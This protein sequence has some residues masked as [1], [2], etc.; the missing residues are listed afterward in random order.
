V[1]ARPL[2]AALAAFAALAATALAPSAQAQTSPSDFTSATRYDADHRVTGTIAP[3]PD[4]S[5][6]LHY[7]AV[8]NTY[9]DAGELTRVEKGELAAWQSEAIAP[10]D[11]E[12][13]TSFTVQQQVDTAY[14]IMGRKLVEKVLSGGTVYSLTQYSYDA[15][16]R[17][18]CT[19]LRMNAAIYGSL[20]SSAC[21]LGA[22]G[23]QGPDRITRNIYDAAD[24]LLKV[25]KAYGAPLQQDYVTYTYS[26]N[27]KQT[28]VIDANGNQAR[29][30]YDGF[31]RLAAWYF[32]STTTPGAASTTDYEAYG[33]DADGNRTSLRKRDGQ[34]I[35]YSYD[36]LNR[37]LVKDIPGGTWTDVYYDYDLAGHQLFARFGSTSGSGITNTYD[38]FGRLASSTTAMGGYSRTLSYQYD[39]DGNR[40]RITHPDGPWFDYAYDGLDR[41]VSSSWYTTATGSVQYFGIPYD[42]Q[43]RRW[44]TYRASSSTTYGYDGISRLGADAQNFSSGTSNTTTTFGY[45]PASQLVSEAR[46]ND[47]YAFNGYTS[48]SSAYVANGLNQYASVN[49]TTLGYDANGNL[50]SNGGTTFAYDVE[51][52]LVSATGTL[53]ATLTYD[54]LGRLWQTTGA[55]GTTQFLYD[56]DALV[57]EYDGAG[58][59]LTRYA[60]GPGVDEPILADGGGALNCSQSRFLHTDHQGSIVALADCWGNPITI[61]RYD[62]YGVPGA[63]NI[64]RFQYT[65]Q[66]YLP[67]LGM[68]YY[69]AR[70]YSSR[71]GRFLQTDPI[72]Y[73]D[74]IDLYT[75][76]ANDPVNGRD[77]TGLYTT[78]CG[79]DDSK[80]NA[81]AGEFEAQRQKNLGSKD[82][83]VVA[84]AQSYGDRGK[85][86][87]VKV[88]FLADKVMD[89]QHGSRVNGETSATLTGTRA[90]VKVD[91]RMSLKGL[92]MRGVSGHEGTHVSQ[93]QRLAASYDAATGKYS[94]ALNLTR[95]SMERQA[96]SIQNIITREFSG[97][98]EIDEH[99]IGGYKN[100]DQTMIPPEFAP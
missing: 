16:G 35:G 57:A 45:N 89:S 92:A 80:C 4:G 76:V 19:A 54:P 51:N 85:D 1:S 7:A 25:Q 64:G 24:Q 93:N 71:L 53:S 21:T 100:L 52:R 81:S 2:R 23:N 79:S 59:M 6:P 74:Q 12:S 72:G 5:G 98:R 94:S 82:G 43:G 66:A 56:G 86:N 31:D 20:P 73:K 49:G 91:I 22:E 70:I 9:D 8:R 11:W 63:G 68:Y 75:Y 26:P 30:A 44:G 50:T 18:D 46:S 28:A 33:Y 95:L 29:Y 65:G 60:Y 41:M 67:D 36:A 83:D 90:A 61:N 97:Q 13:H 40:M 58:N 87:G 39:A 15:A 34:V 37:V 69:K 55:S 99:I 27:G 96:Y 47:A 84:S 62:E 3:D 14:D 10:A 48:A 17:L 38:G 78:G 32:P 77:P 42:A 88:N